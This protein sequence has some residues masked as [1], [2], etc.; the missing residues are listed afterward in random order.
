MANDGHTDKLTT[1]EAG[2][3]SLESTTL[4]RKVH[5]YKKQCWSVAPRK[6]SVGHALFLYA[7]W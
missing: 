1:S 5:E 2:S 3:A 6:G 7:P 4:G